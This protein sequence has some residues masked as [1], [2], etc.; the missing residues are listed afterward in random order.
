MSRTEVRSAGSDSHLGHVF[1]DGPGPEGKRFC[2]NSA[3][4]RFVPADRLKEEGLSQYMF[5]FADKK[6]W[7]VATLA[8]GCFWGMQEILE[9]IP[10]VIV[11]QVDYTGGTK[12][13]ATYEEVSTGRTGH[14]ESLQILFD[15]KKV[16]YDDV[17]H[18]V[19]SHARSYDSESPGQ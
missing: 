9:K 10:G 7:D 5:M 17:L 4:L 18:A 8:G 3:A 14:A 16:S 19:L 12:D 1:D 13:H 2:M 11:T 6:G 15:P